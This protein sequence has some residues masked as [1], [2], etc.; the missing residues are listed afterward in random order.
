[1]SR[2]AISDRDAGI[3][4]LNHSDGLNDVE[5]REFF[6]SDVMPHFA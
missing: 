1:M 2:I 5:S 6:A 3:D 4:L